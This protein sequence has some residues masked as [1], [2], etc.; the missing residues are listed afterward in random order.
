MK[1][2]WPWVLGPVVC[3]RQ[4]ACE[5]WRNTP[6]RRKRCRKTRSLALKD[7]RRRSSASLWWLQ[8]ADAVTVQLVFLLRSNSAQF[9]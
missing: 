8:H 5:A 9:Q 1:M 7:K 4:E 6:V 2:A 3:R